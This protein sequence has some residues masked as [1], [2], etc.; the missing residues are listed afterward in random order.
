MLDIDPSKDAGLVLG[1][2]QPEVEVLTVKDEERQAW[3]ACCKQAVG[4]PEL[5]KQV[6]SFPRESAQHTEDGPN[7]G[8]WKLKLAHFESHC[9]IEKIAL[10]ELPTAAPATSVAEVG[11]DDLLL[12]QMD[13]LMLG[14]AEGFGGLGK[15]KRHERY[16]LPFLVYKFK[17]QKSV[18][19]TEV[20]ERPG[21]ALILFFS[22]ALFPTVPAKPVGRAPLLRRDI[23]QRVLMALRAISE[24][25]SAT[26]NSGA[27]R[28]PRG[29]ALLVYDDN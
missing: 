1:R 9:E 21:G 22:L 2:S 12:A 27:L 13:Q 29:A 8:D 3:R 24:R 28:E 14:D 15:G 17:V 10:R 16:Y 7:E 26:S 25:R 5:A 20:V 4:Q 6:F 19:A 11:D 18:G 23:S